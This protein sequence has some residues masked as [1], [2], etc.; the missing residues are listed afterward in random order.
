MHFINRVLFCTLFLF[1]QCTR[2][3]SCWEGDLA[4]SYC[5]SYKIGK[6]T[7]F[8]GS[9]LNG[10]ELEINLQED[11]RFYINLFGCPLLYDPECKET[12]VNITIGD[13]TFVNEGVIFAGGQRILLDQEHYET[14]IA[15]LLEDQPIFIQLEDYQAMISP[16]GFASE[17]FWLQSEA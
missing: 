16:K 10:M 1:S 12:Q 14:I 8:G 9:P 7:S 4:T 11:Q 17:F 6:I 13:T 5:P 3:S 15:A 2:S